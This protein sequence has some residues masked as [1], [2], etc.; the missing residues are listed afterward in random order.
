MAEAQRTVTFGSAVGLH[1]RP[2]AIVAKA[3]AASGHVVTLET[4]AGKKV[5]AASLLLLLALG[6]NAGDQITVAVSGDTADATADSLAALLAAEL[7][8]EQQGD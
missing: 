4:A 6:V 3:A 1:S 8:G 7:D 5:N 2:A